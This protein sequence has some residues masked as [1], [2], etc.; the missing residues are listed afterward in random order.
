MVSGPASSP[1]SASLA[2]PHDEVNHLGGEGSGGGLGASGAGLECGL[3]LGFVAGLEFVDPG[4]VY[5]V[6]GGDFGGCLVVDEQG[7][8]DQAGLR[9]GLRHGRASNPASVSPMTWDRCRPC[10]ETS[11]ADVPNQHTV[12]PTRRR[13][14]RTKSEAGLVVSAE[15][16][17]GGV[18]P[19]EGRAGR[20]D[21]SCQPDHVVSRDI[22]MA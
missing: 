19:G 5:A 7:G 22:G 1:A 9:R 4:S 18:V 14:A 11:V 2:E 13:P 10:L 3:A 21:G 15:R 20:N 12:T 8:K 16:V 17:L 6:S